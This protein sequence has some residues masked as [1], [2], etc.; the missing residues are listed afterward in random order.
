MDLFDPPA[1]SDPLAEALHHL[2]MSGVFY[3]QTEL[4]APWGL[5]LPELSG[6]LWFHVV[7]S[8][9]LEPDAGDERTEHLRSGD[10]ALVT[11]GTG[12]V[13]RSDHDS[14]APGILELE[15]EEVSA[16][17]EVLRHGGGGTRTTLVCGAVRFDDPA[18]HCL[19]AAL[20]ALITIEALRA[21]D[22]ERLHATLSLIAAE[23]K[24][25]RP[26]G[27][28]VITR[29]A[30]VLVIQ[31]MRV[32]IDT[33]PDART[34]WFGALRDPQI[35]RAL[36]LIH[37]DP[38]GAWTVARLAGEVGMSRSAFAARFTDMVREPAMQ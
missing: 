7:T 14:P 15:R 12:H 1:P 32:W 30:D 20:P 4:T 38:A 17:Y 3:C 35:G 29:L 33:D 5:T 13:L 10:L 11:H 9:A 28:A 26:G 24:Q 37:A 34:G 25:P 6:Y 16:R 27:E 36:A 8:G 21:R 18:A 22:I 23:T 31:A 2:R 19:A